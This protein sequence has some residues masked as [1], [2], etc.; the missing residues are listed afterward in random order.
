M[1]A[2][3]VTTPRPS[4]RGCHCRNHLGTPKSKYRT[5]RAAV[6]WIIRTAI[7]HGMAY[8]AYQC[9]TSTRWHVRTKRETR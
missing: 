8:E 2:A 6:D 7:R 3:A 5:K 4:N 9:P 1:T